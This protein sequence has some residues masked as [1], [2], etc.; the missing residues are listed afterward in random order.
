MWEDFAIEA[1]WRKASDD[2]KS[3]QD[4]GA[5]CLATY[6]GLPCAVSAVAAS[7]SPPFLSSLTGAQVHASSCTA[8]SGAVFDRRPAN[9][10]C[11]NTRPVCV[12]LAP[13]GFA[14]VEHE[15]SHERSWLTPV[16]PAAHVPFHPPSAR[17]S[18]A[19][20]GACGRTRR[21]LPQPGMMPSS[22]RQKVTGP[23]E[24]SVEKRHS[25]LSRRLPPRM[26]MMLPPLGGSKLTFRTQVSLRRALTSRLA[27]S[28]IIH[29]RLTR[30]PDR[31]KISRQIVPQL[32]SPHLSADCR[33]MAR[34]RRDE[35]TKRHPRTQVLFAKMVGMERRKG[36]AVVQHSMDRS[37]AGRGLGRGRR[38]CQ[39]QEVGLSSTRSLGRK[40]WG[41]R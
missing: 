5:F 38:E 37:G 19:S 16:I 18:I 25:T 11:V 32:V 35:A 28:F 13:T 1:C 27:R 26:M 29:L 10:V 30:P 14:M 23:K 15:R 33:G 21:H 6:R 2:P 4:E 9:G 31:R 7:C 17:C 40:E 41:G 39:V 36:T 12:G 8:V 3:G 20:C 24:G 22:G 34:T